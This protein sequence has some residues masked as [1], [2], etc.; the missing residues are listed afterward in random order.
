MPFAAKRMQ[1]EILRLREVSQD[2]DKYAITYM[3]Y[4]KHVTNEL[5]HKQKPCHRHGEKP[6]GF[7]GGGRGTDWGL[8]V[9]RGKL[10]QLERTDSKAL[11]YRTGGN[12]I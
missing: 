9:T 6:C 3:W 7:R 5:S 11:P 10:L 1:L 2:E 4:L 12:Y 8:G